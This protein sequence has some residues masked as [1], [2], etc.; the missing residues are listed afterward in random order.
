MLPHICQTFQNAFDKATFPEA[1][2]SHVHVSLAVGGQGSCGPMGTSLDMVSGGFTRVHSGSHDCNHLQQLVPCG[3]LIF[4][5][6]SPGQESF[7][8]D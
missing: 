1:F 5:G 4:Q 2:S 7:A 6:F 3:F 8:K